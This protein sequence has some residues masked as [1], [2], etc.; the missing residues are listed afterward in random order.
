M[1]PFGGVNRYVNSTTSADCESSPQK[2][3]S[4]AL[5]LGVWKLDDDRAHIGD[6]APGTGFYATRT[7]VILFWFRL[8]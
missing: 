7:S 3:L 1:E 2:G 4:L 8:I 6:K 5:V